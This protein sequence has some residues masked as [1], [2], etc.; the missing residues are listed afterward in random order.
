MVLAELFLLNG[1]MGLVAGWQFMRV[2][3]VAADRRPLLGGHPLAR[4][5]ALL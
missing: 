5:V 4:R 3:L 1:V 2:G